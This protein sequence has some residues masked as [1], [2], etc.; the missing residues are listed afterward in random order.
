M[1]K[2]CMIVPSFEAKGG[3]T[4]VVNGY[5]GS[6]LEKHFQMRYIETYCD[7]S[8][9]KKL[10]KAIGA[11]LEFLK[12]LL[13]DKPD[14]LHIHAAFG[15]SF[16]R[17]VPFIYLAGFL[18]IPVII[19]VHCSEM[20]RFYFNTTKCR[21][22][23]IRL[24]FKRCVRIISLSERLKEE[25]SQIAPKEKIEVITNYGML[26]GNLTGAAERTGKH[27]LFLGFLSELKGCLDIPEIVAKVKREIGDV[28]VTL[29]GTGTAEAV[30][31]IHNKAEQFSTAKNIVMPGWVRGSEK[32]QL[33]R[34]SDVFVLPSYTEA[35]PMS[36]LEAMG[37]GLPVVSTTVGGIPQLVEHGVNGY[38]YEPGDVDGFAE[39]ILRLLRDPELRDRMGKAGYDRVKECFSF[40]AHTEKIIQLY[41]KVILGESI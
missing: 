39:G 17:K 23:F 18:R 37:Y 25:L 7:G 40:E 12:V 32:A 29:A 22:K 2:V 14:L 41:D 4:T 21:Q 9:W 20:D 34:I 19:H 3:I 13:T 1:K 38:L 11:Y 15:A 6:E 30:A 35:L 24:T 36:I 31:Q 33:L 28:Q 27:V 26:Q 8:K 16:Y 10:G 5:P